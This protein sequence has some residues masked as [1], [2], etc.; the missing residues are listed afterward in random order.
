MSVSVGLWACVCGLG[1]GSC[2]GLVPEA[3]AVKTVLCKTKEAGFNANPLRRRG[4]RRGRGGLRGHTLSSLRPRPGP[5]PFSGSSS[6]TV[7]QAAAVAGV[8]GSGFRDRQELPGGGCTLGCVACRVRQGVRADRMC[9]HT[10]L[11]VCV[12]LCV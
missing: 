12:C 3:R 4:R 11:H 10:G 9:V 8:Q 2:T 6:T 5:N 1:G 7:E